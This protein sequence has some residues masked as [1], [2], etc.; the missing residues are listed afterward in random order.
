[1]KKFISIPQYLIII[2]KRNEN[3][4]F[5][6][7]LDENIDI[8]NYIGS[9]EIIDISNY[10]LISFIKNNLISFCKSPINN[11][12]YK[13]NYKQNN[14]QKSKNIIEDKAIPYLLIYKKNNKNNN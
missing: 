8:K 11:Q 3:N 7:K 1:M 14:L 9:N 12:W 13:Y 5:H 10:T 6:F 2:I 4:D